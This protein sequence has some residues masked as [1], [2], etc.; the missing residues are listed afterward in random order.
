MPRAYQHATLPAVTVLEWRNGDKAY[1]KGRRFLIRARWNRVA[2]YWRHRR[3]PGINFPA[4]LF[5]G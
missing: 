3:S 4:G 1:G 5:K 2:W